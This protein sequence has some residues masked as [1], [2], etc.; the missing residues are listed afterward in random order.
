MR[1]HRLLV[2]AAVALILAGCASGSRSGESL[3]RSSDIEGFRA[4]DSNS[5]GMDAIVA[6]I[7]EVD[8]DAGCIW[9]SDPDGARYPVVWPVGT[10]T[11]S[12]PLRIVLADGQLVQA[13]DQVEGG[14]GYID[15]D[16][17][18][19][20]MGLEPFPGACVQVGEAA[21]F[22]AG[23]PI[24][25]SPGVGLDVEETLVSRFSPPEPIGL[26]LIAV[27]PSARSVAV[28]DFVTGTMHRY[29]PGQYEAP[30]DIIDGAS[31]G[32]GFI[33]LWASGTVSTYWPLDSEPLVYR[34]DPLRDESGRASALQVLPASGGDHTW[35]VQ[36]GFDEEPTLVELVNVLDFGLVRQ[37]STAIEGSWKPAGATVE[38]L[39]LTSDLPEP[40]TSLVS[41]NGT[42]EAELDGTAL[43]VGWNGASIL[44]PDGSLIV[45]NASLESPIQVEKPSAG[46]W[47]S[48]GGPVVPA[49]SPPVRTGQDDYLLMLADDPDKGP[50]GA[51]HLVVVDAAGRATAIHELSPGSHLASWSRA[52]D[53]VVVVED[54]AVELVSV[55]D[56]STTQL[57]G[58][59][60]ESFWVLTAG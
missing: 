17:A 26:E 4:H 20:G 6:G 25:V 24:S 36:P 22:N 8:L 16:A 10:A 47:V 14:G 23:S 55:A 43:S 38:G 48:V 42:V 5:G 34:P 49:H 12:D 53:W 58:L 59:I 57:G 51:G 33:H 46:A 29:E 28:V 54:S 39:I 56:G 2:A 30:V 27:N 1:G 7:V 3:S 37:I 11:Q 40:R 52:G 32:G 41:T 21:V 18:T 35:L 13:G 15:A 31:G 50:G 9:L 44:R 60:P 19:S 45:T